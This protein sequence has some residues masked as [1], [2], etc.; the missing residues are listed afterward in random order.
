MADRRLSISTRIEAKGSCFLVFFGAGPAPLR[1][2]LD[3]PLV[4]WNN[5]PT[6]HSMGAR[7]SASTASKD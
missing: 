3:L 4:L 1:C 7:R 5:R 6:E 2:P